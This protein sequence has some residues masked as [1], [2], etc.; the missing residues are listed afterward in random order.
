MPQ[1]QA[2]RNQLGR[3]HWVII[4]EAHHMIGKDDNHIMRAAGAEMKGVILITV[5]PEEMAPESL[6]NIA[7]A[8]ILGQQPKDMLEKFAVAVGAATT[9]DV[10][11]PLEDGE[12]F[13]WKKGGQLT[14]IKIATPHTERRRHLKKYAE[15]DVGLEK[16][17]F[18]PR[19]AKQSQSKSAKTSY[20]L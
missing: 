17:F 7:Q 12:A 16:S 11:E 4:D 14:R 10:G 8:L 19:P 3:P 1:V 20:S 5:H 9:F 15:G 13:Y 18:L 6:Q 2:M